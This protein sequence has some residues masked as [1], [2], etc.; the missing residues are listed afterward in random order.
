M[1]Q[2]FSESRQ[3]EAARAEDETVAANHV[4][5][6]VTCLES[7]IAILEEGIQVFEETAYV[8]EVQLLSSMKREAL[9][10]IRELSCGHND[11]TIPPVGIAPYMI[12]HGSGLV[13]GPR[14]LVNLERLTFYDLVDI[15]GRKLPSVCK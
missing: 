7:V 9:R 3:V 13:G 14:I 11:C 15:H 4:D 2:L 12:E 10:Y 8:G 6:M 1:E 5:S